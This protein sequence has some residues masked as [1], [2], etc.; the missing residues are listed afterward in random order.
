[1]VA[2]HH[3]SPN[4]QV[5]GSPGNNAGSQRTPMKTFDLSAC[6]N[7]HMHTHVH[8]CTLSFLTH[9]VENRPWCG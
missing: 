3:P 7:R 6:G 8:T 5:P 2:G 1:M 4:P 9:K